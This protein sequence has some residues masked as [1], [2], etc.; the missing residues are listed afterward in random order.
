MALTAT[1]GSDSKRSLIILVVIALFARLFPRF[2]TLQTLLHNFNANV[3]AIGMVRNIYE[4]A[5]Q[6]REPI[7]DDARPLKVA[8][9]TKLEICD[10]CSAF[11]DNAVLNKIDLTLPVPGMIP[12]VAIVIIVREGRYRGR[13]QQDYGREQRSAEHGCFPLSKSDFPAAIWPWMT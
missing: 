9:P 4:Q 6:Q 7:G 12:G 2:T 11:A 8:L 3:P 5:K 1:T 10:L 13:D